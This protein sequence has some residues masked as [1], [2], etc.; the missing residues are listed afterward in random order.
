MDGGIETEGAGGAADDQLFEEAALWPVRLT[1]LTANGLTLWGAA[2]KVQDGPGDRVL[3]L[4]CPFLVLAGAEEA[5]RAFVA[6]DGA[7]SIAGL[8]G[9]EVAPSALAR[10][11]PPDSTRRWLS[12]TAPSPRPWT[13]RPTGGT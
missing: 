12:T 3:T 5:L 4:G 9:Y 11:A 7:S 6:Q 13:G 1:F 2:G 8:P 10:W